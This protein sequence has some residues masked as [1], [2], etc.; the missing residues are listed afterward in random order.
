MTQFFDEKNVILKRSIERTTNEA[1]QTYWEQM[2][3][4]NETLTEI[5]TQNADSKEQAVQFQNQL[6][7]TGEEVESL[8]S[9]FNTVRNRVD[10]IAKTRH[11]RT[12]LIAAKSISFASCDVLKNGKDSVFFEEYDITRVH[13]RNPTIPHNATVT[14]RGMYEVN[15][16]TSFPYALSTYAKCYNVTDSEQGTRTSMS[17]RFETAIFF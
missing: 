1:L 10:D 15:R 4:M 2:K 8:K 9:G 13:F 12:T 17:K 3:K 14:I 7:S 6:K 16:P 11:V 5:N